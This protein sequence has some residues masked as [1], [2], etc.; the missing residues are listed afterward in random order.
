[1]NIVNLKIPFLST[2]FVRYEWNVKMENYLSEWG[3]Q[4]IS[5][6]FFEKMYILCFDFE[7]PIENQ[8]FHLLNIIYETRNKRWIAKPFAQIKSTTFFPFWEI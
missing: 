8:E 7:N 5:R 1:M 3:L 2:K 6:T 4:I